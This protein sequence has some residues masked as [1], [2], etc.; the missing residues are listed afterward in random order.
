MLPASSQR[1]SNH[2]ARHVRERIQQQTQAN[3][4]Y[5]ASRGPEAME[6]RL[7][8]LEH[9]W[10]IERVLE[11]NASSLALLGVLLGATDKRW[12]L[13]PAAVAGFLLQHALQGWCPPLPVL[14]RLGFRTRSEIDKEKYAL[15][16]LRGDFTKLSGEG[17]GEGRQAARALQ[18][19]RA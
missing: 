1:V 5:F 6:R 17:R 19:V 18:A 9:E 12:L 8:E 3:V 10:D 16:A 15:K 14:R 11:A 4:E 13:L 2:T 7:R